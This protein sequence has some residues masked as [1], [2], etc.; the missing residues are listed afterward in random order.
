MIAFSRTCNRTEH[1]KVKS[2]FIH[3]KREEVPTR[4]EEQKEKPSVAG[5]ERREME[6]KIRKE[7]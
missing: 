6:R 1:Q 4:E 5:K 2:N 7:S 3:T